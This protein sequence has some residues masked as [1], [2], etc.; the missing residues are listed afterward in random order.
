MLMGKQICPFLVLV[1]HC[2]L[3][4]SLPYMQIVKRA[5][6]RV[7]INVSKSYMANEL[8]ESII[9]KCKTSSGLKTDS[10]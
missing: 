9:D 5:I 10:E 4:H 6:G 1:V 7:F 3:F 2:F 8:Y